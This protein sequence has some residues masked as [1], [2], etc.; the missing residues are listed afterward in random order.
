M[1]RTS[2]IGA[3]VIKRRLATILAADMAGYSRLM[4]AG[5]EDVIARQ[6]CH[7]KELIAPAISAAQGRIVKTTGDGLLAEFTSAGEAVRC[8]LDIQTA[9]AE[10][11]AGSS[12][13]RRIRY[14]IGINIG[15]V[16][17]ADDDIFGDDVNVAA[18]L[19]QMAE[20]GG[21][22]ISQMVHQLV[23][24][25]LP[26]TFADL[27]SQSVKNIARPIRVWQW[28]PQIRAP[29][30]DADDTARTQQIGFCLSPDGVQIA[31][32]TV[33]LGPAVF[34]APNWLNHLEYDWSSPIWGPL[35][36]EISRHNR[37]VRFD[38]RGNGLSDWDAAE[39]SEAAMQQ[40]M[41]TVIA[42]C[43]LKKFAVFAI[44][45]GCAIAVRYASRHPERVSCIVMISGFARGAL[46]RGSSDQAALHAATT[47][48]IRLGWGSPNPAY[49]HL[50]TENFI[51]DASPA[52]KA[53][54]DELQR[55]ASS[56]ENAARINDMNANVDVTDLARNLSVPVLVLHCEGDNR[57]PLEEGRRLA[58]LIP[59]AR[60][61][62]LPGNNHA[63]VPGTP[64]YDLFIAEFHRFVG[65]HASDSD[66]DG[67]F[68]ASG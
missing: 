15:D 12:E 5:E 18:R 43:G 13:D 8:A 19:E 64:S 42:A 53:G 50:F 39:I 33:G 20:P 47:D 55:V 17:I 57:V 1:P 26:E 52:Q 66:T 38:Q 22:C 21:V 49:R 2:W 11:E 44:S 25:H 37:L 51:P 7:F 16:V 31:H 27:G 28:T 46:K 24:R 61:V 32:A 10:R 4:E 65:K 14:R 63:L 6:N 34:K 60:F 67:D 9:M 40:D 3:R 59:G 58:A 56:P 41:D 62:T 30:R 35:L 48:I 68:P 29:Y 23:Q 54:F 36:Q 45:Q